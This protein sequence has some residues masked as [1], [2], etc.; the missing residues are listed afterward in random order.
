VNKVVTL[1]DA[2][3]L[4]WDAPPDLHAFLRERRPYKV[5]LMT[6]GGKSELVHCRLLSREAARAEAASLEALG[7]VAVVDETD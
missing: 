5:T 2:M 3:P 4:V 1:H 6:H 7:F